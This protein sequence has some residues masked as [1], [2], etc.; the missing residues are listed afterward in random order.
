MVCIFNK[1]YFNKGIEF[2]TQTLIFNPYPCTARSSF[3]FQTLNS[4]RSNNLSL[5]FQRFKTCRFERII[6]FIKFELVAKT[7]FLLHKDKISINNP[8]TF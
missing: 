2:W 4:V 1:V 6:G 7:Q 8:V 5:K 3:I